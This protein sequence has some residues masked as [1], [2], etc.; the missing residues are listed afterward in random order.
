[1]ETNDIPT[2]NKPIIHGGA[3]FAWHSMYK[4]C[5]RLASLWWRPS[6]KCLTFN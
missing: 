6:T 5:C 3:K 2:K 4:T 1:M